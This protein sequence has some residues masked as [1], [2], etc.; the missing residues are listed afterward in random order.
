MTVAILGVKI[1]EAATRINKAKLVFVPTRHVFFGG[2][3]KTE[4]GGTRP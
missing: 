4:L 1:K 2:G 3:S